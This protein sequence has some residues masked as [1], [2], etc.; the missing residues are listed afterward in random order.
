MAIRNWQSAE[1]IELVARITTLA[2]RRTSWGRDQ[3]VGG[4]NPLS[5]T[6]RK[7][8]LL[9]SICNDTHLA[10]RTVWRIAAFQMDSCQVSAVQSET[11]LK[12][13]MRE[14][15]EKN[16]IGDWTEQTGMPPA[17][18]LLSARE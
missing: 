18:R 13:W 1:G 7:R 12:E 2:V 10:F 14:Q 5:S 17:N 15:D 3:E 16:H 4:S 8:A 9:S 6:N 11:N